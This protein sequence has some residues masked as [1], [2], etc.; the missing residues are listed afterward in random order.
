MMDDHI[1][2]T[3]VQFGVGVLFTA[4]FCLILG[5]GTPRKPVDNAE[6]I[7]EQLQE[8]REMLEAPEY[9]ESESVET[10]APADPAP[11]IKVLRFNDTRALYVIIDG[12]SMMFVN[13]DQLIQTHGVIACREDRLIITHHNDDL[14]AIQ[15]LWNIPPEHI[16]A[17]NAFV[18]TL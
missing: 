4:L 17:L 6:M 8:I 10:E 12:N 5:E 7:A 3:I 16:P 11:I 13:G 9:A 15:Q 14:P 18:R 1:F 2:N